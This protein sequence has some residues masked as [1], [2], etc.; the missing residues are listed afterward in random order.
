MRVKDANV[1]PWTLGIVG[2]VNPSIAPT[3][4]GMPLQFEDLSF[5]DCR[6]VEEWEN[7]IIPEVVASG[8]LAWGTG[9]ISPRW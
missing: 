5:N 7:E 4:A 1:P 9:M 6:T 2:V 3:R 8:R